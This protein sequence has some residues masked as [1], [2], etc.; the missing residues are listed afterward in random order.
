MYYHSK[1]ILLSEV[2][3]DSFSEWE[4]FYIMQTFS[5]YFRFRVPSI[6]ME[7]TGL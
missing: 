5:Q 4:V 3:S 7:E 1:A 2:H 6:H